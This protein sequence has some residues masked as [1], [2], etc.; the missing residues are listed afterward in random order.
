VV[1]IQYYYTSKS[2]KNLTEC[3]FI[4]MAPLALRMRLESMLG[5]CRHQA[6]SI[7]IDCY[8]MWPKSDTPTAPAVYSWLTVREQNSVSDAC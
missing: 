2:R 7:V 4:G 6:T 8:R 1:V 5:A 3:R